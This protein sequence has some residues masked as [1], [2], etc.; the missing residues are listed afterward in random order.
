V[1]LPDVPWEKNAVM[2]PCVIFDEQDR[3]FK[4]WYSGG[5]DYEPDAI[6]YATSTDG[7]AWV[8]YPSNPIFAACK[9]VSWEKDRV[10]GMHI[11][12]S[13]GY[14]IGFYIGFAK[15]FERAAVGLARSRNGIDSWERH[16]G[17]P[18]V[19]PGPP[20]DWDDC[21]VYKPFVLRQEGK[22]MLWY[23]ASRQTDRAEQIGV[24]VCGDSA[25]ADTFLTCE[26]HGARGSQD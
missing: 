8:K 23:N 16:A 2:C 20:G 15:G 1:L 25:F 14:Y 24:A 9:S 13:D 3:L 21:N 26:Q 11:V 5:E 22:W 12:K 6:G 10:T 19:A 4:M 17:N 18:I 7:T